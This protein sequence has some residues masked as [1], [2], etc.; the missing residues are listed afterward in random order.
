M[1]LRTKGSVILGAH[2]W[3]WTIVYGLGQ[4][5]SHHGMEAAN[6]D[7]EVMIVPWPRQLSSVVHL[8]LLEH[9]CTTHG[10]HEERKAMEVERSMPRGDW[11]VEAVDD[12]RV[13]ARIARSHQA[14]WRKNGCLG[15]CCWWHFYIGWASD[16]LWIKEVEQD[17]TTIHNPRE[18]NDRCGT[19]SS[20]MKTLSLGIA[21]HREDE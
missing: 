20:Y 11:S 21:V 14:L 9:H 5:P 4:E 3:V 16:S 18:A 15:L 2:H 13:A 10:Y 6:W 1:C 7:N 12:W 19:L 8:Q 17:R